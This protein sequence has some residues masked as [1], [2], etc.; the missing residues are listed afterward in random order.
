MEGAGEGAGVGRGVGAG[1]WEVRQRV[2]AHGLE[3]V[4]A[5]AVS[6]ADPRLLV[7]GGRD[8]AAHAWRPVV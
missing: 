2:A 8:R 7:T 5:L 4:L 3:E 1:G 6:P